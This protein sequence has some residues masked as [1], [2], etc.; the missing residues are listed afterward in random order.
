V[1]GRAGDDRLPAGRL[2]AIRV[3]GFFLG[4][5]T[6]LAVRDTQSGLRVYPLALLEAVRTT[7]GG[8]VFETEVLVAAAAGGF[9][10]IEVDATPIPRAGRRSRFRPVA[11]GA[12]IGAYLA[13]CALG[14]WAAEARTARDWPAA[15]R[16]RVAAAAAASVA[17]PAVL[18][19][20]LVQALA[21]RRLP[22]LVSPVVRRLYAI[23]R[24]SHDPA[25]VRPRDEGRRLPATASR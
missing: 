24:L 19:L 18:A 23:D 9:D 22:D 25:A 4:W 14:R 2:N 3:A 7:R 8:F 15:R 17:A 1:H 16:R 6:G 12:A 20:A 10:V 5:A 13:R 11:D 21:G